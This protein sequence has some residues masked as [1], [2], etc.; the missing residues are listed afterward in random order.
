[1]FFKL[2]KYQKPNHL[3]NRPGTCASMT[4]MINLSCS[5]HHMTSRNPKTKSHHWN[6]GLFY[7]LLPPPSQILNQMSNRLQTDPN[8]PKMPHMTCSQFHLTTY[9]DRFWTIHQ[10]PLFFNSKQPMAK[11]LSI[12][13]NLPKTISN[14]HLWPDKSPPNPTKTLAK[15]HQKFKDDL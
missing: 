12:H 1:M 10:F 9:V 14:K 2:F 11:P 3:P 13:L 4:Q 6:L 15:V 5:Y 7:A 8:R